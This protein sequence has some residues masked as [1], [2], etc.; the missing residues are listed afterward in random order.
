M[1]WLGPTNEVEL[2]EW[3]MGQVE[4]LKDAQERK[5]RTIQTIGIQT[6]LSGSALLLFNLFAG[7]GSWTSTVFT[8]FTMLAV[9]VF[10][11]GKADR[12][13]NPGS[14]DIADAVI[15]HENWARQLDE[16]YEKAQVAGVGYSVTVTY[17][18]ERHRELEQETDL[19][20]YM[21]K[22]EQQA[23][24]LSYLEKKL[25]EQKA[26]PEPTRQDRECAEAEIERA[27][28]DSLRATVRASW[29]VPTPA[30]DSL[31][32]DEI[33][34]AID[35]TFED[36]LAA[37]RDSLVRPK[38]LPRRGERQGYRVTCSTCNTTG[39]VQGQLCFRCSG[40]GGTGWTE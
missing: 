29:V 35:T 30:L 39:T 7:N 20:G 8:A 22:L 32:W 25:A 5:G 9:G 16:A 26:R 12:V 38:P 1:V 4:M 40:H 21:R 34:D 2:T 15:E 19:R 10:M 17:G 14:S 33:R 23:D 36:R 3:R 24:Q 31:D 11:I 6:G 18:D 27:L 28:R 37:M 13:R